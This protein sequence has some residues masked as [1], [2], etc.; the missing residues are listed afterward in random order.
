MKSRH[1]YFAARY[2]MSTPSGEGAPQNTLCDQLKAPVLDAVLPVQQDKSQ[3]GSTEGQISP[4]LK[5]K[6]V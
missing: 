2:C 3:A 1:F 5:Q 4:N 6:Q